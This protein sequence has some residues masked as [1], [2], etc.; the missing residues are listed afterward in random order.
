MKGP[1]VSIIIPTYYK[2]VQTLAIPLKSIADQRCPKDVFEVIIVD[3]YGGEIIR[4]LA[5]RNKARFTEVKGEPSQLCHQ[6]NTGA[7]IARGRYIL[8][9][10]HDIEIGPNLI[11]DLVKMVRKRTDIGA[12][13]IPYRIIARGKILTR[14]RNFEEEFYRDSVIAAPRLI[15]KSIFSKLQWDP[16]VSAGA[17]DWDF[18]IQMKL[19]G[20]KF[21]YLKNYFYHHEEQMSFWESISKKMIYSEGGQ[22]YRRKWK[23]NNLQVYKSIVVKQY[24]PF[25]RL[26]GIFVD[27]GNW[28][29]L[30]G[31][32]D[33][34]ILF[35]LVK[36]LMLV[37]YLYYLHIGVKINQKIKWT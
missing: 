28:R 18:T 12:W 7:K 27:K 33:I 34:Y 29:R 24:D 16:K 15:K 36:I 6:I 31:S 14:I 9:L 20:I 5:R 19:L 10:D 3:N 21:D 37:I 11:R 32:L 35:L 23:N 17:P 1:V 8:L 30:L 13:Y 26:F 4:S 25:F 2:S 22:V